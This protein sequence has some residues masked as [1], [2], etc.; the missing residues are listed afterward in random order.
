[1][2]K[3]KS[4]R[5]WFLYWKLEGSGFKPIK[6]EHIKLHASLLMHF[7]F[8]STHLTFLAHL[9]FLF[10]YNPQDLIRA[11]HF[12]LPFFF[13]VI[14]TRGIPPCKSRFDTYIKIIHQKENYMQKCQTVIARKVGIPTSKEG[15]KCFSKCIVMQN[16]L[17]IVSYDLTVH[18]CMCDSQWMSIN[19]DFF[20]LLLLLVGLNKV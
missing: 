6:Y 16:M 15:S 11:P 19:G 13:L 2:R 12:S 20:F 1:M 7:T 9:S 8:F 5:F 18:T 4:W 3:S 14:N 10:L 17:V